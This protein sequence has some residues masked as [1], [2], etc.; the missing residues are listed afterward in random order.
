MA[1]WTQARSRRR[2]AHAVQ[3]ESTGKQLSGKAMLLEEECLLE[4][5]QLQD[6]KN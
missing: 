5:H 2:P 1:I 4:N 3:A 6:N